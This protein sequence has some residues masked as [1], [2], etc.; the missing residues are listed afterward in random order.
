MQAPVVSGGLLHPFDQKGSSPEHDASYRATEQLS[1]RPC[2]ESVPGPG[3]HLTG[4]HAKP[5]TLKV[6]KMY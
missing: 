1:L 3:G 6:G 4:C 2:L 5:Y